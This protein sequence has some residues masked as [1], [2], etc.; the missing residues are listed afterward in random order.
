MLKAL[1]ESIYNCKTESD[2]DN[3]I[4][5]NSYLSNTANWFPIG[6]NESNFSIIEN[7]QSNPIAALVEKVTNSIDATLM[8]KCL[9]LGL[10]PK[11]KEAPKSMDE[12]IDVFFPD[13]KNWDLNTFRRSQAEDIQIIA[14][15]PTKQS[16][17]IIYDNGEGQHPEDFENTFLSLMRGN[18]NEIHFVQG[19]YNMGGSGAIVFCGTKGYQLIA[20]KRYDGSGN[21][22]FTLVREH[23]L[24]K[25]ELE[26][27]KNTWYEY[28]KI[29]NKIPAFDIT[30][31]D[32][33]LLNRKFKTGSIIKMYSYQ[34]KGISGFAQDLNQSLNE[35]LF[36]PVLP[37]FTIDTKERYPN[38]KVLETTVYGLQRRLEEEK[39]Y[40][41]DWFSEEYEDVLFG[42]MKVTCYVFKAKQD[43]KTV[44]ETKADIQRRYFKNNMSVLFSMN[45][46]VHGHYTSEFITRSLKYNLLK[47][48]LLINVDCTKMKYEFRKDL[49]MASRDRLKNGAKAEELRDYLRKKLTKSKLDDINKRRKDSIGLESED[50][51]ELIKSFA[52]NLSKDSELF[53]LIQNTLKLEEKA[54][55]K[56]EKKEQKGNKPQEKQQKPFKPERFPSF[57]KMQHKANNPIPV[58]VG[59]EKTL[60]F[61]TDVEDHYFD[62]TDEPG[63]LQVS[64]LKVKRTERKGGTQQGNEKEPGELLNIIKSSPDKG[65]IKITFNPDVDLRQGDEIEIEASLKG[66]GDDYFQEIVFLKI[67]DPEEKKETA[68]KEEEDY[69]NIGLPEL[70]KVSKDQWDGLESQGISMNYE[71]VMNPVAS[72]DVLEKIYVNL[73]SNV[74]LNYRKKLKNEEQIIVAQKRYIASVYFHSL[75]LYM[76]TKKKNYR[77]SFMAEN[78]DE[79]I[80]IDDYIRDV[81][82]SYYSDFLLNFGMEQLMGSLED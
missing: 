2:L 72:G 45:G 4:S 78:N 47:D 76:I 3:L 29:D 62:R 77:L 67:V 5:A 17:V 12:A 43:G 65:T 38:N 23:P 19:K 33:K 53:K 79:E 36:K 8:K 46:Q 41:E 40:V 61:E 82:D 44:K 54:K 10:E 56:P 64:V 66:V 63:D 48:Y 69:S 58:P 22:G 71:T 74:Y 21:F 14:D 68:P 55:E 35:F 80:T 16:S 9:Q 18:K 31:L 37:V 28:L 25:D 75:F 49:F 24:S 70:V 6:Q 15:G 51:S 20:S 34:M 42:K 52:K 50:T 39:D 57:F 73:D 81:F 30:E 26:T 11:S 27:K 1:F 59:G 32:L 7:Q 13:N 60:R